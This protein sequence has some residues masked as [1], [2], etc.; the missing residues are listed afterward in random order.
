MT[1]CDAVPHSLG[2]AV[3]VRADWCLR[4]KKVKS[5]WHVPQLLRFSSGTQWD[6][7]WGTNDGLAVAVVAIALVGKEKRAAVLEPR[8]RTRDALTE[9]ARETVHTHERENG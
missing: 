4:K 7:D 1:L 3:S 9:T 6:G 8:K 5:L 2:A